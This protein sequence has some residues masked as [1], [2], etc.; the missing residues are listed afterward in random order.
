MITKEIV[1]RDDP[2]AG[3]AGVV[4]AGSLL[5]TSGCDG[6]IDPQTNAVDPALTGQGSRQSDIS[7]GRIKRLLEQAGS[8]PVAVARIDH[9]A[10]SQ[11]WIAERQVKRAEYFGRPAPQG[12]TGVAARMDGLNMLTTAVIAVVDG[13][14]HEV[15]VTGADY[16]IGHISSLVRAG[17]LLILSGI[18]GTVDPRTSTPIAEETTESFAAQT[19]VCYELII[20]ILANGGSNPDSIVRL[21]RYVRDRNRLPDEDVI[22]R[23][24]LGDLD[25]V[26]TLIPLPMGMH[27]EVEITALAVVDGSSK[28]ICGRDASARASTI[29]AGGFVF[30]GECAGAVGEGASEPRLELAGDIDGQTDNALT[31]L[32]ERLRSA[33]STMAGVVRLE[34]YLRD[35][36]AA[37]IVLSKARGAFG[38]NPPAVIV[39]GAD[40]D[41]IN[42]VKFNAIAV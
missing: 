31:I 7:Y 6:H 32:G 16:A 22:N 17:P 26:S 9:F 35:I 39:A 14:P 34:I 25:A 40:L 11:D 18:R 21:D 8:S 28:E 37:D 36:Y 20:N 13:A 27:G 10:S 5:F 2:I 42:E 33:D 15:L 1:V 4:R 41:G 19:R 24:I 30:I 23:S 3:F 12:S 29:R 38:D